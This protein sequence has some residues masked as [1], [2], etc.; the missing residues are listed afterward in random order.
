MLTALMHAHA[1]SGYWQRAIDTSDH[2]KTLP[3]KRYRPTTVTYNTLLK[4]YVL[5][6]TPFS[7]ISDLVAEQEA[8]GTRPDVHTFALLVQS[9]CDHNEFLNR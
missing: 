7:T 5:L 3:G 6:S 2:I 8:L 1:Q 4:A 9:A